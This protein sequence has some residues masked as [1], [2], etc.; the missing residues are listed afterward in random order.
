MSETGSESPRVARLPSLSAAVLAG[1][2][3]SRLGGEKARVEVGGRA[4]LARALDVAHLVSDDVLLAGGA[5][6]YAAAGARDL[7][8]WPGDLGPLAG[9]GAALHAARHPWVLLLACD[10]PW[11]SGDVAARLLDAAR[12]SGAHGAV[13]R[14]HARLQPF[15]AV[16]ARAAL[17]GLRAYLADGGRALTGWLER[18]VRPACLGLDDL[19]PADRDGAF[20]TDV[21]TPDDLARAQQ[22]EALDA[23]SDPCGTPA[24]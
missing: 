23:P 18:A 6:G 10:Q 7:A 9:V 19:A 2:A 13:I 22:R 4:L 14:G 11:P 15:P 1:G 24:R 3:A 17:P 20:L 21:D 5:R 8:D 12:S 16:I